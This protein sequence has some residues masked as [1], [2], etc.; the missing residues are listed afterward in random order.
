MREKHIIGTSQ[1]VSRRRF[2]TAS[3]GVMVAPGVVAGAL[4]GCDPA[5]IK[6]SPP[7]P[8]KPEAKGGPMESIIEAVTL[9]VGDLD[10]EVRFYQEVPGLE[11]LQQ[12]QGSVEMGVAGGPS[13]L[14]LEHTPEAAARHFDEAGLFHIAFR[15]P[16]EAAL[17]DAL[18]RIQGSGYRLTGASDHQISHA[19]Y[20]NDPEGNGL[21][22]YYDRPREEW[23]VTADGQIGLA[24]RRLDLAR[25][26]DLEPTEQADRFAQGTDIG[27]IHLE[28]T[29]IDGAQRFYAGLMG[30]EITVDQASVLF[31][32]DQDYH[33]HIGLN[34]W[35]GRSR[36][37]GKNTRGLAAIRVQLPG[38]SA[39]EVARKA[40]ALGFTV[41]SQDRDLRLRDGDQIL[42]EIAA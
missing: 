19:L 37:A 35:N 18:K 41:D 7:N 42:W 5:G 31:V 13:L 38:R 40:Q 2:L 4:A 36:P 14:I 27:H 28:V 8:I 23:P 11:V 25:L 16:H 29:N 30:L 1:E 34:H 39:E 33:H 24:T 9:R 20:L 3:L 22:I 21:E 10:R 17:A 32:A 15:V 6:V 12:R 26:M